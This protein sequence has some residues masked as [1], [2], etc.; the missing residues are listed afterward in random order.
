M[1]TLDEIVGLSGPGGREGAT[2][3]KGREGIENGKP[4]KYISGLVKKVVDGV[5]ASNDLP[6]GEKLRYPIS[7]V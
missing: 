1:E 4:S 5:R 3:S 6:D 2:E 7:R